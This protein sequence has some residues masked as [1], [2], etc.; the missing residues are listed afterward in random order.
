GGI[1]RDGLGRDARYLKITLSGRHTYAEALEDGKVVVHRYDGGFPRTPKPSGR[2]PEDARARGFTLH[3]VDCGVSG[4][5]ARRAAGRTDAGVAAHATLPGDAA[6]LWSVTLDVDGEY[7][8]F[9]YTVEGE[10]LVEGN[11]DF[12]AL[13]DAAV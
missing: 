8:T 11:L 4:S 5:I 6:L 10:P 7:V 9:P 1:L 13:P 2:A 12:I 3:D